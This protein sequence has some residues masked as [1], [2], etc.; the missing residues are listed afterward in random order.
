MSATNESERSRDNFLIESGKLPKNDANDNTLLS[1]CLADKSGSRSRRRSR[2]SPMKV[3][4]GA[5]L[6]LT[7]FAY[8]QQIARANLS[9]EGPQQMHV[10]QPHTH[11]R[12]FEHH[13]L[14]HFSSEEL[15]ASRSTFRR[16]EIWKELTPVSTT[17]EYKV[18][19]STACVRQTVPRHKSSAFFPCAK[20]TRI[21]DTCKHERLSQYQRHKA[22]RVTSWN[23]FVLLSGF[24][25]S[26]QILTFAFLLDLGCRTL[27]FCRKE[28]RQGNR[29]S[30]NN[31]WPLP[32]WWATGRRR[33]MLPTHWRATP[34]AAGKG[35]L[36]LVVPGFSTNTKLAGR[37]SQRTVPFKQLSMPALKRSTPCLKK[38]FV[39]GLL[40]TLGVTVRPSR[41]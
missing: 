22:R 17:C 5:H 9:M 41:G 40:V 38:I 25:Y 24:C 20:P 3:V 13:L 2:Q 37:W 35:L 19:F 33:R 34:S 26:P 12:H 10:L 6:Q 7:S 4:Q 11:R 8:A 1:Y 30:P 21:W 16:R 32:H 18:L 28:A 15:L 23:C 27:I 29:S 31:T 14:D 39:R 36:P